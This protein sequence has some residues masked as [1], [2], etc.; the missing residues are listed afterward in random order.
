M[1][2]LTLLLIAASLLTPS[3]TALP[4]PVLDEDQTRV[5]L[6]GACA[7]TGGICPEAPEIVFVPTRGNLWGYHFRGTATVF[8]SNK[9]LQPEAD[10][11]WCVGVILHEMVHYIVSEQGRMADRCTNEQFAWAIFNLWVLEVGRPD[12]YFPGWRAGYPHCAKE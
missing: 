1:H 12:L 2:F 11:Q 5:F 10:T 9:C 8:V 4:D 7:Y 6:E 3:A